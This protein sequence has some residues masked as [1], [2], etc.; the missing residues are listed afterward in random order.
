[1]INKISLR[2]YSREVNLLKL[3]GKE[4]GLTNAEIDF[5]LRESFH[6]LRDKYPRL[7]RGNN[8]G[9]TNFIT[10]LIVF[11]VGLFTVGYLLSY[12]KPTHNFVERNIQEVIYP[13]MK[14]YRLLTLPLIGLFPSLSELYDEL[15]LVENPYFQVSNMDCWPCENVRFVLNITDTNL[16]Y[17]VG[18]PLIIKVDEPL[19]TLDDIA[20]V[21]RENEEIFR[22]HAFRIT[23]NNGWKNVPDLLSS[24]VSEDQDI[25]VIWRIN[26]MEP[27]RALRAV[28]KPPQK[29]PNHATAIGIERYLL[30]DEAK[31]PG[32]NLPTTEGANVFI[33][34]LSGRRLIVLEPTQECRHSCQ[35]MSVVLQEKH[36]LWYNWWYWRPRSLPIMN[37]TEESLAF[38]GSTA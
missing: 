12:H 11:I 10:K 37:S 7:T 36:I 9:S 24:T 5:A 18:L 13:F 2:C 17:H 38:M 14:M 31:S 15:C 6:Y 23:S 27:T 1:M 34:Q 26:R 28:L 8:V 19:V 29:V 32:Y 22:K 30:F 20:K 16:S 33:K 3:K 25:H 21:Y 4:W 35:R